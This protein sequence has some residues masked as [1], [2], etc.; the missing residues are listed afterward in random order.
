MVILDSGV[1]EKGVKGGT[2]IPAS[3]RNLN[4]WWEMAA[5]MELRIHVYASTASLG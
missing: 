5:A 3:D 4:I 1:E 2:S